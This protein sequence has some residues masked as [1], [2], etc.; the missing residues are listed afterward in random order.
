MK[1]EVWRAPF[2]PGVHLQAVGN[3]RSAA[4]TA[5]GRGMKP[6]VPSVPGQREIGWEAVI[7]MG[8]IVTRG[9]NVGVAQR[10][11]GRDA[12]GIAKSLF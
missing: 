3:V 10:T 8:P 1:A 2:T 12:V 9:R 7:T 11:L 6:L 5:W 4:A